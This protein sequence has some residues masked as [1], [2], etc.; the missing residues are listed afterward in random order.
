MVPATRARARPLRSNRARRGI[1]LISNQPAPAPRHAPATI[2]TRHRPTVRPHPF[3]P[4][5]RAAGALAV[6]LA[7]ACD[8]PST[9]VP[10]AEAPPAAAGSRFECRADRVA[11]TVACH[12]PGA[13]AG[14]RGDVLVGGAGESTRLVTS[15]VASAADTFAFDLRVANLMRTALGTTDGTTPDSGGV[16]VFVGDGVH[17]TEGTGAVTVANP[18]GTGTFTAAGQPF[19][20]YRQVILPDSTSAA[21]RWKLRMDPGVRAFRF[22]LYVSAPFRPGRAAVFLSVLTPAPGQRVGD[23]LDVTARVDSASASIA[24]VVA[25]VADRSVVLVS[26]G[27]TGRLA[28]AGL[29][30]GTFQLTV[31]ATA[32]NGDTGVVSIPI[33]HDTPPTLTVTAP[34]NGTV[35]RPSLRI[36]A[37]CVDDG[38]CKEVIAQIINGSQTDVVASGTSAI[39]ADVSLAAY[40]TPL[41]L[42]YQH[43]RLI[44]R[45]SANQEQVFDYSIPVDASTHLTEIASAGFRLLDLD[46]TRILA[47][48]E[49]VS[50]NRFNQPVAWAVSIT[51]RSGG[52]R[53]QLAGGSASSFP[54]LEG[55][56]HTNGALFETPAH[57]CDRVS[58]TTTCFDTPGYP[59]AL[60]FPAV[61][62]DWAAYIESPVPGLQ[63][64]VYARNLATG[65]SVQ[66]SDHAFLYRP[67]VAANGD[68]VFGDAVNVFR[69]HA[70][71]LEPLTTDATGG[72]EGSHYYG[73][74]T[75]GTNVIYRRME[76]GAGNLLL[77]T[78]GDTID[79]G[80]F[81][82]V[83][84]E[85]DDPHPSYQVANGWTAFL[86]PDGGGLTQVWVRTP[87]G[88]VRQA[89]FAGQ[90][91]RIRALGPGGEVA[92]A[93]G[94]QLYVAQYPY[95][96][97]VNVARDLGV[98]RWQGGG[99]VLYLGRSAFQVSY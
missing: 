51:D 68:V 6:L 7:A 15:S 43:L 94:G 60:R 81:A 32:V 23:T 36:D 93:A 77:R 14:A 46:A 33:I 30:H 90:A 39:H 37:D 88:E 41:H 29:P 13:A 65:T 99:L 78:P 22:V 63:F 49:P 82:L 4:L 1:R 97:A 58:G 57:P 20:A 62:G 55:R 75:D 18:D 64:T 28:L 80:S 66:V 10:V 27:L 44:A 87:A 67:D 54:E 24:S 83:T 19:F 84:S 35:A 26:P 31:V 96:A 17:T 59:P 56:L 53:T 3:S 92:F 25:R 85:V 74:L 69:Y 50:P 11:G 71:V 95:A 9:P 91:A 76:G 5:A 16:K 48:E 72:N 79:L 45:D 2:P 86:R 73:P 47:F 70:G 40:A 38:A 8:S 52:G 89:S 12:V 34:L 61:A 42:A 98:P 21:R